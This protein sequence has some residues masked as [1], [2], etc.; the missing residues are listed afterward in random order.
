VA[1]GTN[2]TMSV[3]TTNATRYFRLAR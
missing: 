1:N 2:Y 3:G